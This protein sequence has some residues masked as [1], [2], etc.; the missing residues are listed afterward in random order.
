[1]DGDGAGEGRWRGARREVSE[2]GGAWVGTGL[3]AREDGGERDGRRMA[4]DGAGAGRW[5]EDG[6]G[7][8]T[9]SIFPPQPR[10]HPCTSRLAPLHLPPPPSRSPPSSLPS[11]VP[12]HAPAVSLPPIIPSQPRPPPHPPSVPDNA[13]FVSLFRGT[14]D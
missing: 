1:M 8:T 2:T 3:G 4:G 10:P 13:R 9:S 5:R 7:C 12:N 11:P 14:S 6:D